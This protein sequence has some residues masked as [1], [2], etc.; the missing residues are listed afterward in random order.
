[1]NKLLVVM[2]ISFY[3]LWESLFDGNQRLEKEINKIGQKQ[4]KKGVTPDEVITCG[5][6]HKVGDQFLTLKSIRRLYLAH[7]IYS[8]FIR[9]SFLF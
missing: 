7:I 3:N 4:E 2:F 9:T 1:M 5:K 6:V 8:T